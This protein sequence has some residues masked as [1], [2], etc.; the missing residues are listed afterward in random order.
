MAG[1]GLYQDT[2]VI[3]LNLFKQKKKNNIFNNLITLKQ[4]ETDDV[5]YAIYDPDC[6]HV[7]KFPTQYASPPHR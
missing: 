5:S 1:I 2:G 6:L 7:D 4:V 3:L